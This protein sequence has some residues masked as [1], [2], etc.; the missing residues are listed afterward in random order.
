MILVNDYL[1]L[2][3]HNVYAIDMKTDIFNVMNNANLSIFEASNLNQ[4]LDEIIQV[5]TQ[6]GI[7]LSNLCTSNSETNSACSQKFNL[8]LDSH[9]NMPVVD[10]KAHVEY[11]GKTA[12]VNAF[13]SQC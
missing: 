7:N 3:I 8:E 13:S 5:V 6:Q 12:D 9:T 11:I 4:D 2:R 1:S 10:K